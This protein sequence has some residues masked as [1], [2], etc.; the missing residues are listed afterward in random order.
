MAKSDPRFWEIMFLPDQLDAFSEADAIRHETEEERELRYKK[1][2]SKRKIIPLI[3][4]IV[5]T[6]PDKSGKL[7]RSTHDPTVY[8]KLR[9]P[10]PGADFC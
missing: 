4:D 9:R 8:V 7:S 5:T 6:L 1:E 2:D 10:R 3:M